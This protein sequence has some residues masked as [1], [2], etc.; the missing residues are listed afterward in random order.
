VSL[1]NLKANGDKNPKEYVSDSKNQGTTQGNQRT[2]NETDQNKPPRWEQ[3][4]Q[5]EG[6]YHHN[7]KYPQDQREGTSQREKRY[8]DTCDKVHPGDCWPICR[9]CKKRHS[10]RYVCRRS[11]GGLR[12]G[13]SQYELQA[14]NPGSEYLQNDRTDSRT[15]K[16]E[17]ATTMSATENVFQY[18]MNA[19]CLSSADPETELLTKDSWIYDTGASFHIC[20][21][22]TLMED[23]TQG[24]N[25][26][27]TT[28][29]GQKQTGNLFGKVSLVV[30]CGKNKRI[31]TLN[32]VMYIPDAPCNLVS[33]GKFY[34]KGLYLDAQRNI[35]HNGSV[36][37]ANCPRLECANVR[38]LELHPDHGEI[39]R[40][41]GYTMVA[42]S[43]VENLCEVWQKAK[44][45]DVKVPITTQYLKDDDNIAK[46]RKLT[47][48]AGRTSS[49]EEK[50]HCDTEQKNNPKTEGFMLARD[51]MYVENLPV[52]QKSER[53]CIIVTNMEKPKE[54]TGGN[55]KGKQVEEQKTAQPGNDQLDQSKTQVVVERQQRT[56]NKS[57]EK[58]KSTTSQQSGDNRPQNPQ[59]QCIFE[60]AHKPATDEGNDTKKEIVPAGRDQDGTVKEVK[61]SHNREVGG[62]LPRETERHQEPDG[63][64]PCKGWELCEELKTHRA[65]KPDGRF[66]NMNEGIRKKNEKGLNPSETDENCKAHKPI[67]SEQGLKK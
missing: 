67:G 35:I 7:D 2:N 39:E 33:E 19:I 31:I 17:R 29:N 51:R 40:K 9:D 21:N 24:E 60:W 62:N 34:T 52:E 15:A 46:E 56:T 59:R 42:A 1:A 11:Q 22:W 18:S 63:G 6:Q 28:A 61:V 43:A 36:I 20:N 41:I 13:A 8:C 5:P 64:G 4:S 57:E 32:D 50:S 16:T 37:A 66:E 30:R 3:S 53:Q 27:T 54:T 10:P 12:Q 44:K 49:V 25:R 47:L 14:E 23:V 65:C 58:P 48:K 26:T 38:T 45:S 55:P